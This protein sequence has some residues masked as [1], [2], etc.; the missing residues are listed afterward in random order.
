MIIDWNSAEDRSN[1]NAHFF[2]R[3]V[4][5]DPSKIASPCWAGDGS[6]GFTVLIHK[7]YI[8]EPLLIGFGGLLSTGKESQKERSTRR[9]SAP[10]Q[11]M[12]Q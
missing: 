7:I 8:V 1:A 11:R 3:L 9:Q 4:R 10:R 2:S 12:S 6:H 5:K